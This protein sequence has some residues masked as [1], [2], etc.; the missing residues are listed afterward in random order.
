MTCV[1][2]WR[3]CPHCGED[4]CE[5]D[6]TCLT[7]A[8]VRAQA[9]ESDVRSMT[10]LLS[11][12]SGAL[13]DAG[14]R[15]GTGDEWFVEEVGRLGAKIQDFEDDF[16]AAMADRDGCDD[17]QHCACVPHL[18]RAL[19]AA[20]EENERLRCELINL[21]RAFEDGDCDFCP[22]VRPRVEDADRVER[23]IRS[24][25]DKWECYATFGEVRDALRAVLAAADG[26]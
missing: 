20:R 21:G 6:N 12:I 3:E 4:F 19:A 8:I 7:A 9:A 15:A 23:E 1:G 16:R 26:R 14:A 18:R 25:V 13:M 11:R 17:R 2:M 22:R 5:A 24:I 10:V